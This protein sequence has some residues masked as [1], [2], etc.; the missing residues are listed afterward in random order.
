MAGYRGALESSDVLAQTT[1]AR[2]IHRDERAA[3]S[4]KRGLLKERPRSP[5]IPMELQHQRQRP[6]QCGTHVLG[7]NASPAHTN[8]PQVKV[9]ARIKRRH[10]VRLHDLP[11]ERHRISLGHALF[12]ERVKVL[13]QRRQPVIVRQRLN[14]F[15]RHRYSSN[16]I[17]TGEAKNKGRLLRQSSAQLA[18]VEQ[19]TLDGP[20]LACGTRIRPL[21]LASWSMRLS[22]QA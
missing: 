1:L 15:K 8:K 11:L 16:R 14:L 6:G 3:H 9:L 17:A 22:W 18:L 2:V 19:R 7:I 21:F 13:R 20:K 4:R 10:L 12:P 5:W